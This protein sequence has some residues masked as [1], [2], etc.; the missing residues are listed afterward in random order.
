MSEQLCDNHWDYS[1]RSEDIESFHDRDLVLDSFFSPKPHCF[2]DYKEEWESWLNFHEKP[3]MGEDEPCVRKYYV[4]D[5]Q[6]SPTCYSVLSGAVETPHISESENLSEDCRYFS[7]RDQIFND[8][9]NET[10]S[11]EGIEC[12]PNIVKPNVGC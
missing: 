5:V 4:K 1:T 11:E 2:R 3:E 12:Q 8:T 10:F 7:A 6:Q 9:F